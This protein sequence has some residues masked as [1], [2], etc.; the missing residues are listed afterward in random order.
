VGCTS[1]SAGS[2][3]AGAPDAGGDGFGPPIATATVLA[4]GQH[5]PGAIAVRGGEVYWVV[6]DGTVTSVSASGGA[7]AVVG[8]GCRATALAVD[9]TSAY[10]AGTDQSIRAIDLSS[11]AATA[12]AASEPAL[13]L[14][15]GGQAV[16]FTTYYGERTAGGNAISLVGAVPVDGG[17]VA[18]LATKQLLPSSIAVDGAYAYWVVA[19]QDDEGTHPASGV[20]VV[21]APFDGGAPV[22]L[23]SSAGI[24]PGLSGL[25]KAI[26]VDGTAV[27]FT[28]EQAL[29]R[30][31]LA[32]G[33]PTTLATGFSGPLAIDAAAAYWAD[34]D[35]S[36]IVKTPLAGGTSTTLVAGETVASIAVDDTAVYWTNPVS[37]TV[38][39]AAK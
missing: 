23:G 12:L 17:A 2:S 29:L 31:P 3:S 20:G 22:S 34:S 37:G 8:T 39:K 4:A 9:A 10:C 15:L 30:L 6:A 25:N 7:P 28:D 19:T 16:F 35:S 33:T 14:A 26:A 27:Y 11:G 18:S 5:G 13:D 24:S 21:R 32:G 1:G 38:S 36:A